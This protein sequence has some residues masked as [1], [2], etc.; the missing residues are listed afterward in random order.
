MESDPVPGVG[1]LVYS[2]DSKSGHGLLGE[3]PSFRPGPESALLGQL[4]PHEGTWDVRAFV[5]QRAQYAFAE[6]E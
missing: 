3:L 4:R 2:P 1:H 6:R 5:D